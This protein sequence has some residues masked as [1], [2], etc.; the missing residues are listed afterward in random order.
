MVGGRGLRRRTLSR[1]ACVLLVFGLVWI[2]KLLGILVGLPNMPSKTGCDAVDVVGEVIVL[3][4]LERRNLSR[5]DFS[6]RWSM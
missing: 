1:E 2:F 5:T 6:G 3:Y 4:V